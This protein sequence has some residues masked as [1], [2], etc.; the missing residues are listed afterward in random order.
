MLALQQGDGI[1]LTHLIHAV[2]H[3]ALWIVG[4]LVAICILYFV[5]RF[6]TGSKIPN[7]P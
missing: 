4:V 6:L 5:M 3:E 1:D 2:K 7:S